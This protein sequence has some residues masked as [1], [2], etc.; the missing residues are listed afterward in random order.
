ALAAVA[1]ERAG[2]AHPQ[3]DGVGAGRE[4]AQH[5][6]GRRARS[7]PR[8]PRRAVAVRTRLSPAITRAVRCVTYLTR[9]CWSGVKFH[10]P[11]QR[12]PWWES[13]QL[14]VIDEQR[15]VLQGE[16]MSHVVVAL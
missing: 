13:V 9:M 12:F 10:R 3:A 15:W 14:P 16:V 6:A 5:R 11:A 1:G 2:A 7:G 8:Q 4:R